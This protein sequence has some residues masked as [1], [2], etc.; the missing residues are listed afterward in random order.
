VDAQGHP[1]GI[2]DE[3]RAG[4]VPPERRPWTQIS[5]VARPIEDGLV[6]PVELE[7]EALVAALRATPSREYLVVNKDGS[8][9]GMLSS[10]DIAAALQSHP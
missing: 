1:V 3:A 5:E 4:A 9:A 10:V 8:P 7:G 6:L 2:V